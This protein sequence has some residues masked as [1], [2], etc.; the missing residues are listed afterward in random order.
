LNN[1]I[2][3]FAGLT[4]LGVN[5]AVASAVKGFKTV[6]YDKND[7]V[8]KSLSA[9]ETKIQEPE[10]TEYLNSC[11][12][13]LNFSTNPKELTKCDIVYISTDVPTDEN[14]QSDL[15]PV[16]E[17]L[18]V[19][20]RNVPETTAIVVLCQVPPGFSRNIKLGSAQLYYQVETLIFGRAME[21]A[22]N[23]ERLIIGCADPNLKIHEKFWQFLS[24]YSCPIL[25]MR[26]ES[27]ELCKTAINLFLA[28]NVCTSNSL[29][30]VCELIGAD[31]SEIMPA[32]RLD[33]RIGNHA[34]IETGLG[35]SG[36]NIERDL[37]TVS[38]LSYEYGG[39]ATFINGMVAHSR[40]RKQWPIQI[41]FQN[42]PRDL[43]P[44]VAILGVTYKPN[45]HS[46]KNSPALALID[47]ISGYKIKAYD[48]A[49]S[50]LPD[51][52]NVAFVDTALDA[53]K[54]A[55]VLCLMT[56]WTQIKTIDFDDLIK[57]MNP[58][59]Q[60]IIDPFRLIKKPPNSLYFSLGEKAK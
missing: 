60:L 54:G 59:F 37:S 34:Y 35:I 19:V 1:P 28:A 17:L 11:F 6:G 53:T 2:I 25:Q 47:A 41:F 5:S 43:N 44:R 20:D 51:F 29:A 57:T 7:D 33:K 39:N 14:G 16:I 52:S 48:P 55:H 8:I 58:D 23:P 38:D 4:H 13:L 15:D 26:Y 30:E 27:A 49:V 32:L 9:G 31:W 50:F 12:S 21:R 3:G 10:L 46:V 45:T 18:E 22:L 56:P 40:Y 36:G 42:V 24:A